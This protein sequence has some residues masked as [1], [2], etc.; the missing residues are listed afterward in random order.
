MV[1]V[2]GSF[3]L[4][5]LV[6]AASLAAWPEEALP[7]LDKLLTA[8]LLLGGAVLIQTAMLLCW[9]HVT[10]RRYYQRQRATL[11][12]APFDGSSVATPPPSP[13]PSP[14][15]KGTATRHRTRRPRFVPLPSMLVLPNLPSLALGLLLTGLVESSAA[16]IATNYAE[17][18]AAC[19]WPAFA[20]RHRTRTAPHKRH[21]VTTRGDVARVL[22]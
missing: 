20:V 15:S 16:L 21:D 11:K 19:V 6:P 4:I 13:P 9:R 10:N 17:C 22:T 2:E 7:L 5:H 18:G 3:D 8:A 12:F 14:P 1:W